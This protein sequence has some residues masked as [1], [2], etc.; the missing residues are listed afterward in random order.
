MK[1]VVI[2]YRLFANFGCIL[3]LLENIC[4][5]ERRS[6][7]HFTDHFTYTTDK[8]T[9]HHSEGNICYVI[10]YAGEI[11]TMTTY[12]LQLDTGEDG[13]RQLSFARSM[14]MRYLPNRMNFLVGGKCRDIRCVSCHVITS[15]VTTVFHHFPHHPSSPM[16]HASIPIPSWHDTSHHRGGNIDPSFV[17]PAGLHILDLSSA[18][19]LPLSLRLI[20]IRPM[21]AICYSNL[22]CKTMCVRRFQI[23]W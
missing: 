4:W 9:M 5:L 1:K 10:R 20:L 12:P 6:H 23:Q 16:H 8:P 3:S 17:D 7:T 13:V 22:P 2:G 11:R 15:C 14:R 19:A 21:V 18:A